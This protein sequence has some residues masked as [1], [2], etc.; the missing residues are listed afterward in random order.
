MN[1]SKNESGFSVVELL[2]ILVV[3]ALIGVAAYFVAKHVNTTNR[4]NTTTSS[5]ANIYAGWK[6]YS[7]NAI[8]IMYPNTW[9]EGNS[10]SGVTGSIEV[11]PKQPT[12]QTFYNTPEATNGGKVFYELNFYENSSNG[13]AIA[14]DCMTTTCDI[15]AI[16]PLNVKDDSSAKLIIFNVTNQNQIFTNSEVVN[17]STVKVGSTSFKEGLT[18]NGKN[19]IIEGAPIYVEGNSVAS[20]LAAASVNNLAQFE[21][22]SDFQ[23]SI[24]ILNSLVV[25]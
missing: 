12:A 13:A 9:A 20:D 19:L 16:Y 10:P 3:L 22:S 17:D 23:N 11:S 18:I 7:D 8:S 15:L 25:K 24:K 5:T 4:S 21:Q 6:S 14:T 1:K 2:L